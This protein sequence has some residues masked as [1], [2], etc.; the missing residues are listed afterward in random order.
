MKK[1]G[2][3][4]LSLGDVPNVAMIFMLT[5]IFFAIGLVI[6]TSFQ[7]AGGTIDGL[8]AANGAVTK[9]RTALNEIPANWLLL[10]AVIVSA[11][12]VIGIVM[13][14]LGRGRE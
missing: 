13:Q 8:S 1:L 9:A 4:G 14:S 11:A 6:L 10:L 7:V 5:G 2:K 3:K 12:V